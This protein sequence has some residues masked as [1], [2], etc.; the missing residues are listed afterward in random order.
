MTL[1]A[2][3]AIG[4]PG[5]LLEQVFDEFEEHHYGRIFLRH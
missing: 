1:E 4:K 5:E 2:W 3:I